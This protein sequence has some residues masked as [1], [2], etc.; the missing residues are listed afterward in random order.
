MA[1]F[2]NILI[3]GTYKSDHTLNCTIHSNYDE[4]GGDAQT[5]AVTS[6]TDDPY[7]FRQHV[8]KQKARAIRLTIKDTSATGTRE[9][10]QLDGIAVELGVRPGTFKLGTSKTLA[11]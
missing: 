8:A 10:F 4:A 11:T 7:I 6:S 1:R 5:K 9:A 3:S 2:Y